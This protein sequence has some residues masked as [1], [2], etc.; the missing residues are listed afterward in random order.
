MTKQTITLTDYFKRKVTEED[1]SIAILKGYTHMVKLI[2]GEEIFLKEGSKFNEL[3]VDTFEHRN[4]NAMQAGGSE[5][6]ST[7][8]ILHTS[9]YLIFT[10]QIKYVQKLQGD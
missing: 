8:P 3:C 7:N 10:N 6:I 1:L 2:D 4:R 5:R 9:K